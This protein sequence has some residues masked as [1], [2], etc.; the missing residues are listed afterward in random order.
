MDWHAN[1][2]RFTIP[3]LMSCYDVELS[4]CSCSLANNFSLMTTANGNLR[5]NC[6]TMTI[7][8]WMESFHVCGLR[9]S[10][11]GAMLGPFLASEMISKPHMC[12]LCNCFV[13]FRFIAIVNNHG[14]R[15]FHVPC[16]LGLPLCVLSWD[17]R[18]FNDCLTFSLYINT[19]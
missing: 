1:G 5:E 3:C 8:R 15:H 6:F 10:D 18:D 2:R 19:L 14:N 4:W 13:I 11:A 16:F 7:E 9:Q 12:A 17:C